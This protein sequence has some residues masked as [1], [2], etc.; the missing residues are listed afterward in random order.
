MFS[1]ITA[2]IKGPRRYENAKDMA[3]MMEYNAYLDGGTISVMIVR[4]TDIVP[5]PPDPWNAR[6]A[7]L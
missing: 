7:I 2:P 1:L 5:E 3:A 6:K 4:A